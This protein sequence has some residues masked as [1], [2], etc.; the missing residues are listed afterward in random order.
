MAKRTRPTTRAAAAK[1]STRASTSTR[2]TRSKAKNKA[3]RR[4]RASLAAADR[5][6]D[7]SGDDS[8]DSD[9]DSDDIEANDD[10]DGANDDGN[11]VKRT[12]EQKR[13]EKR[14]KRAKTVIKKS[15][16]LGEKTE[17]TTFFIYKDPYT[18]LWDGNVHVADGEEVPQNIW[19][20]VAAASSETRNHT[21]NRET[22]DEPH[23][24]Q[25]PLWETSDDLPLLDFMCDL[26]TNLDSNRVTE[27]TNQVQHPL[28]LPQLQ[29]NNVSS[30]VPSVP[31]LFQE[32]AAWLSPQLGHGQ[33]Q[34]SDGM[35]IG[36]IETWNQPWAES[37]NLYPQPMEQG[38]DVSC[39]GEDV[40]P[41]DIN[42]NDVAVLGT[43][44][45][46]CTPTGKDTIT[47]PERNSA[48]EG[49]DTQT[50]NDINTCADTY[51]D[52]GAHTRS[53][54][55]VGRIA[56]KD[57]REC[58]A[59]SDTMKPMSRRIQYNTAATRIFAG[60]WVKLEE[61]EQ[62]WKDTVMAVS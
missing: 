4:T 25:Q 37:W 56:D 45:G 20:E 16:E 31:P 22:P 62:A 48:P 54:T 60:L 7:S 47:G 5:A 15:R 53:S 30:Q 34:P 12:D 55:D 49:N 43:P 23:R 28:H 26:P 41:S 13:N 57:N 59:P 50:G 1:A 17:T 8:G 10:G 3:R 52:R 29:V 46:Q 44:A 32:G 6:N 38:Q 19:H 24:D 18:K 33:A 51:T 11:C 35:L 40:C 36:G 27:D 61:L 9:N 39:Q 14:R 58:A 21:V 2:V 42:L